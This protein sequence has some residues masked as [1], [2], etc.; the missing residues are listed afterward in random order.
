VISFATLLSFLQFVLPSIAPSFPIGLG[1]EVAEIGL[2][3]LL[4]V[5]A[6][7]VRAGGRVVTGSNINVDLIGRARR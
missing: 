7:R 2:V 3:V 5:M 1:T 6:S 4:L